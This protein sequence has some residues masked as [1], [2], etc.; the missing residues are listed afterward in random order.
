MIHQNSGITVEDRFEIAD[1]G[2]SWR[3]FNSGRN[4]LELNGSDRPLLRLERLTCGKFCEAS[5]LPEKFRLHRSE[6]GRS[7]EL[8]TSG[9]IPFG[10]EYRVVRDCRIA[11]GCAL[12]TTDVSAV[13]GGRVDGLELEPLVFPCDPVA[14]EFLIFGEKQFRRVELSGAGTVY[15]GAE[16]P[17]MV[18]AIYHSGMKC[19][20]ALGADVWRHRAAFGIPGA[21]SEYELALKD[22]E[23]RFTRRILKYAPDGEPERRPWRFTILLG[24]NDGSERP[25]PEGEPFELAGCA[26][27]AASRRELRSLVRRSG[28]SLV[29]KNVAPAVCRDA[30]HVSRAGKGE[31]AHFDLEE[32]FAAWWWANRQLGKSGAQFAISPMPGGLFADSVILGCFGNPPM[33]LG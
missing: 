2:A 6:D 9:V 12:M 24:W 13:T 17:L 5:A 1:S 16:V 26:M 33:E 32:Y 14:A 8:E 23:L 20:A 18:R 30:S 10:C 31:L 22:G 27:S 7:A 3:F 21:S 28:T 25:E 29:W 15:S 4:V 19:E 11:S